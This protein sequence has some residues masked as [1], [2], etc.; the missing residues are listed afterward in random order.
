MKKLR[1]ITDFFK[2]NG[3]YILF[4][5][6]IILD[7]AKVTD[8]SII[9]T[10]CLGIVLWCLHKYIFSVY[11]YENKKIDYVFF[12]ALTFYLS[13]IEIG[14]LIFS[15]LVSLHFMYQK[16]R[17][18]KYW[19]LGLFWFGAFIPI[20]LYTYQFN[21]FKITEFF[22]PILTYPFS[23]ISLN[24]TNYIC[25]LLLGV[26]F[27][28]GLLNRFYMTLSL[29]YFFMGTI[30][31]IRILILSSILIGLLSFFALWKIEK[32]LT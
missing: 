8:L 9:S 21:I 17:L 20:G 15:C 25:I 13:F 27:V 7:Q 14:F 1:Y 26:I 2:S 31:E 4:L 23:E 19:A 16:V 28:K 5:L 29:I 10:L 11:K 12:G 18:K 32:R 3:K 22:H 30:T 24:L 6:P